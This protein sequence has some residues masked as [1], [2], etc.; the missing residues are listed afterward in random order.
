MFLVAFNF[1]R[2]NEPKCSNGMI[3]LRVEIGFGFGLMFLKGETL[4]CVELKAFCA[5]GLVGFSNSSTFLASENGFLNSE[6][7]PYGLFC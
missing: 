5:A 3:N 7:F 2:V 6:S 4:Y 1:V